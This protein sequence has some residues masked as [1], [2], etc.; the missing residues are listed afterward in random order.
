MGD[1]RGA[2]RRW[3]L[4]L[5]VVLAGVASGGAL[6]SGLALDGQW[7]RIDPQQAREQAPGHAF[8]PD[9]L[10]AFPA[11]AGGNWIA[12]APARGGW[13]DGDWV[14]EVRSP[15][16]QRVSLIPPGLRAAQVVQFGHRAPGDWPA[17]DRLVFPI[18]SMPPRGEPLKLHID[19][20]GVIASPM[21]FS[22]LPVADYLRADAHWLAY[23]SACLAVMA[24]MALM[25][26][27]FALELA[28][29]TFAWY[30]AFV[31]AYGLILAIQVGYV[32]DPLGWDWIAE[33]P[34]LWGRFATAAS[35]VAAILFL[36]RFA[37]LRR[38]TPR[39]RRLV[40]GYACVTA[41]LSVLGLVP[42]LQ[43][44]ARLLIN[45]L[46]ILGGPLIVAAALLAAC[47]GS[48]YA[49]FYLVG[50]VP[51]LAVTVLGSLQ[52]YGLFADWTWGGDAALGA[53]A[54]DALVLSLGL[55]DRSLALRRDRDRARRLADI[56]PVTGLWNRR[57]WSERFVLLEESARRIR[58]PLSLLFM[59]LD[60]FKA[61]NDEH[62]HEAGDTALRLV[63]DLMRKVLRNYE[64]IGRYGGE[65]F[66]VALPGADAGQAMLIAERI[67][68]QLQELSTTMEKVPTVSIGVATLKPGEG[69]QALIQRAD[70]AMYAAKAAGRNRVVQ[71]DQGQD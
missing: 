2:A 35:V 62:G 36:D 43:D 26:L 22:V 16:L 21:T 58:R 68:E 34:R 37:N 50:W 13:P 64:Q 52:L 23:A 15:G 56:D 57:A 44:I 71:A 29:A 48:R 11:E 54:F 9:R 41:G 8:R 69:T 40:L 7:G 61:L 24:A 65:E 20:E 6:A 67:R 51:L 3:L 27:V 45:P 19:A 1:C 31:I 33:A 14:L 10:Q 39:M 63:A 66:V 70:V 60:H 47:R 32:Y 17:H 25:A 30:A 55:A 28:D 5:L 46:L 12:L 42:E 59:D 18:Q 53:G 49:V 38:H 4:A